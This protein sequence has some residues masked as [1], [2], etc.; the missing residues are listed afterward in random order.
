[1]NLFR[2]NTGCA[3]LLLTLFLVLPDVANACG[4]R[5]KMTAIADE[6]ETSD[7][8]VIARVTALIKG[9]NRFPISDISHSTAVIEKVFKGDVKAGEEIRLG[10]GDATL[11]CSWDFFPDSIG[12]Q[13]LLYL[14]RPEKPSEPFWVSTCRRS[15]GVEYAQD[16]LLYLENIDKLRGR[17]RVSGVVERDSGDDE[18]LAGQQVRITGKNKSYIATTDKDGVYEIY[19][20]PP[21]RYT[22]EP[23]LQP[24]WRIDHW[25]MTRDDTRAEWKRS[26]EGL[27]PL[28]RRSFTLRAKKHFGADISLTLN[29]RIAGRV[30][31]A[32]GEPLNQVCVLLVSPED[33]DTSAC[34]DFTETDGT[35]KMESVEAGS[36]QLLVNPKNIRSTHHRFPKQYYPGVVNAAD[37]KVFT[38]KSGESVE[39]LNFVV[40]TFFETVKLEGTVRYLNGRP[41]AYTTVR[42]TTPKTAEV[43]GNTEA[44][45]DKRGRFS[46]IV[47]KGLRGELYGAYSPYEPQFVDCPKPKTALAKPLERYDRTP[48]L[49]VEANENQRFELKFPASP[50]R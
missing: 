30:T 28:T 6:V 48:A 46:L 22:I 8:V 19:D 25:L 5:P 31:T 49:Q 32:T 29:N 40:P 35:F 10:Q 33:T 1:M 36:Y 20:L 23:I 37:A 39:G 13:F 43:D 34:N 2:R 11:D 47:L 9:P 17:T 38:L 41:A 16:D 21:G 12:E 44:T 27:P 24:G 18:N 4:C 42:F 3:L 15:T 45:T 14:D 26:N 7:L 50:C